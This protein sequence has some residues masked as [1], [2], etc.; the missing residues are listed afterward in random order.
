MES[1]PPPMI[2]HLDGTWLSLP[3]EEA[4]DGRWESVR[5]AHIVIRFGKI[6]RNNESVT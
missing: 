3:M 4:G 6:T 5:P 1:D 2:T